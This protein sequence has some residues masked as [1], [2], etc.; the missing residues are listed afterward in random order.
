ML[1]MKEPTILTI[2]DPKKYTELIKEYTTKN[3]VEMHILAYSIGGQRQARDAK[4]RPVLVAP[5]SRE[6]LLDGVVAVNQS[7]LSVPIDYSEATEA[8]GDKAALK[9]MAAER[10]ASEELAGLVESH[11]SELESG[12]SELGVLC[13]QGGYSWP[14]IAA[15]Q[16]RGR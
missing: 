8:E 16:Q 6:F 3:D 14:G 11:L 4:G 12:M 5:L 1:Y 7:S 2:Q 9:A 13:M 10:A 15:E